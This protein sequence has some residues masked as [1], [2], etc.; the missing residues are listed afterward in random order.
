MKT[1]L[2]AVAALLM[3]APPI[4]NAGI[5]DTLTV[6]NYLTGAAGHEEAA[7]SME[8]VMYAKGVLDAYFVMAGL[9][10]LPKVCGIPGSISFAGMDL[11]IQ[12]AIKYELRQGTPRTLIFDV[13]LTQFILKQL[14]RQYPCKTEE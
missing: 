3:L 1:F 10:Q 4:T 5:G 7:S 14:Q 6:D 12:S 8:V 13:P 9:Q 11:W 2:C